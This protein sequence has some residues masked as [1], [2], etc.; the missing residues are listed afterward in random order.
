MPEVVGRLRT[1]RLAAAPATPVVGEMYYDT[2]TNVLYFWDGT[3]WVSTKS[4][5]GTI[6]DSDPIGAVKGWSGK[7]IPT[8]WKLCDGTRYT[9]ASFPQGYDFAKQ[10]ADAGNTLWTYRTTPDISFT[11]P[12][13]TDRFIL[14]PGITRPIGTRSQTNPALPFPGEETHVLLPGETAMKAHSH[15]GSTQND[16]PDH[17]HGY[18]YNDIYATINGGVEANVSTAYGIAQTQGANTRHTHPITAETAA[19]G[20][21]HNNMPPWVAV[22]MIVKVAGAA[23]DSGG[24]LVGPP[25]P[26]GATGATGST[27]AA[28]PGVPVGGTTNQ[29]LKKNT[30]TDFDTSWAAPSGGSGLPEVYVGSE[31]PARTAEVIWIDTDASPMGS[32]NWNMDGWHMVGA[33]GEPAFNSLWTNYSAPTYQSVGFR[34]S[35]DGRVEFKGLL[36]STGSIGG[37]TA[38]FTL[39]TGYRP[40]AQIVFDVS[41]DG[42]GQA[43]IDV[44]VN[45]VVLYST[46]ASAV[47]AGSFIGLD[48]LSFDTETVQSVASM[49]AQP[50]DAWHVIGAAG[51][52]AFQGGWASYDNGATYTLPGFRKDPTGRVALKGLIKNGTIAGPIFT[53]PVGYRPTKE[54]LFA[55]SNN[56]N[57]TT[58][59]RVRADGT[60]YCAVGVNTWLTLDGIEFDTES[61]SSYATGTLPGPDSYYVRASM[62]GTCTANTNFFPTLAVTAQGGDAGAFG[63]GTGSNGPCIVARDAGTYLV[64][65]RP[66]TPSSTARLWQRIYYGPLASM[67]TL[68]PLD[69][70]NVNAGAPQLSVAN[71]AVVRLNAGEGVQLLI[72]SSTG[73]AVSGEIEV[74]RLIQGAQGPQGPVSATYVTTLPSSP[75]D[76]QEVFLRVDQAGTYGGPYLWHCRYSASLSGTSK[77]EVLA[78][79]ALRIEGIGGRFWTTQEATQSTTYTTLATA[80]PTIAVPVAGVYEME[81]KATASAGAAGTLAGILMAVSGEGVPTWQSADAAIV[82]TADGY[83][84]TIFGRRTRAIA[85]GLS[86][87]LLYASSNASYQARF[88]DRALY[89]RPVRIG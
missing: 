4:S 37:G 82:P 61:A 32:L 88:Y 21:A 25:G 59:V 9:Q 71:S 53:L 68:V 30:A 35:P 44:Q 24:A 89:L 85:T 14:T 77:W 34:K 57:A 41:K 3:S 86:V 39:P 48:H 64:T 45:G 80:G 15:G 65:A 70:G 76:G 54:L 74:T 31:P 42:S 79:P 19:N 38:I 47:V 69:T 18:V 63:L 33:P 12:D 87:S 36:G 81:G 23:I 49:A 55:P 56:S 46:G 13:L 5:A 2:V 50:L 16:T 1:P 20:T 26:T 66:T 72:F 73:G 29:V 52:P 17:S 78:G 6:Y 8:N 75:T 27:G 43:R 58:D 7:T 28:G 11:V 40:P 84:G 67:T 51:E 22:A 60:V 62:S 10:E 83:G